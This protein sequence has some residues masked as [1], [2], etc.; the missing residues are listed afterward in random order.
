MRSFRLEFG[1]RAAKT[2][3]DHA[4][5]A[6]KIFVQGITVIVLVEVLRIRIDESSSR[7]SLSIE[8]AFA[9]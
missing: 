4:P 8:S 1:K 3:G 6:M 2:R 7:M 9:G 5:A